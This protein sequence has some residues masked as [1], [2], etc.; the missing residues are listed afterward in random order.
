MSTGGLAQP[1]VSPC[2]IIRYLGKQLLKDEHCI[3]TLQVY[4]AF[5][6]AADIHDGRAV[7]R[8]RPVA[9]DAAAASTAARGFVAV[10]VAAV[11][12]AAVVDGVL[13]LAVDAEEQELGDGLARDERELVRHL[14]LKRAGSDVM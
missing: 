8:R 9:G 1:D 13:P 6:A 10:A 11:V 2:R 3:H 14:K 4:G 12:A 5:T 7:G